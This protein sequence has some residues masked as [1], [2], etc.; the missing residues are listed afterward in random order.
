MGRR[1]TGKRLLAVSLAAC[2]PACLS[3]GSSEKSPEPDG[4]GGAGGTSLL[5]GGGWPSGGS[6]GSSASGGSSES[7]GSSGSGGQGA[8]GGTVPSGGSGGGCVATSCAAQGLSCGTADDGC[9]ASLDCGSCPLGKACDAANHCVGI[10]G[11]WSALYS[12]CDGVQDPP[13]STVTDSWQIGP[14]VLKVTIADLDCTIT[15]FGTI[16]YTQTTFDL[17]FNAR[18]CSVEGCAVGQSGWVCNAA[19]YPTPTAISGTYALPDAQHL[20][21]QYAG[22]PNTGCASGQ[23]QTVHFSR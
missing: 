3:L 19:S 22:G 12:D 21:L 18:S 23:T 5:G 15:D 7:G 14:G 6:G 17:T 1:R 10:D 11:T 2:L 20:L 4:G 8:T 13:D 16:N 9:G